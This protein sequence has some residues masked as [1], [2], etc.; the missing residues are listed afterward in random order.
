MAVAL[1]LVKDSLVDLNTTVSDTIELLK[2]PEQLQARYSSQES[3]ISALEK[4]LLTS[5]EEE[6][7]KWSE[8][9]EFYSNLF[10]LLLI[11]GGFQLV[12]LLIPTK[13]IN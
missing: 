4:Q 2:T 3:Y 1:Y 7:A 10:S 11:M 6:S 12:I 13:E 8:D 9:I 5:I